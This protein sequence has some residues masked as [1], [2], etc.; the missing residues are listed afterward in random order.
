MEIKQLM[1]DADWLK[2]IILAE[3]LVSNTIKID[4]HLSARKK[5]IL[6]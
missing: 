4:S 3:F 5:N 6:I 2:F 1:I